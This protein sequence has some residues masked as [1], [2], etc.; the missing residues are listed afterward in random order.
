MK[1]YQGRRV[2]GTPVVTVIGDDGSRSELSAAASL[3]IHSHSPD[4]FNWGY[5]G[6]GPAQ[7]ALGLLLD[8]TGDRYE[9]ERLYQ[10]FKWDV[11]SWW[12]LSWSIS[13]ADIR[14]WLGGRPIPLGLSE[15]GAS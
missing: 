2:N 8:A 1:L 4:G 3:K 6:S 14:D 7:L 5:G 13:D 9:A 10:A 15:G 11:V 12:G